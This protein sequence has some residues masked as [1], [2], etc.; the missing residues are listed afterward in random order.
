MRR[1]RSGKAAQAARR[2]RRPRDVP[3]YSR[4]R[5]ETIRVGGYEEA[6]VAGGYMS[7]V[8]NFLRTNDPF[9]LRPFWGVSIQDVRGRE[10]LLETEP[11]LL[12]RLA[13][14]EPTPFAEI[15]RIVN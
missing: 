2:D 6:A 8:G 3:I 10:H 9:Y 15:Y 13:L 4:G 5:P 7:A 11:R 14:I 12:Y 1:T